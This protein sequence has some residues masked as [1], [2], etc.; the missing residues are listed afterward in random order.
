MP[1]GVLPLPQLLSVPRVRV[2]SGENFVTN[3][4]WP[5]AGPDSWISVAPVMRRLNGEFCTAWNRPAA[6][7]ATSLMLTPWQSTSMSTCEA[8][9]GF[10]LGPAAC[11]TTGVMY[12]WFMAS[13]ARLELLSSREPLALRPKYWMPSWQSPTRC[14]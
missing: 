13:R 4:A 7:L 5:R 11:S 2:P 12:S 8:G 14:A 1:Q 6:S 10:G 3:S 9:R